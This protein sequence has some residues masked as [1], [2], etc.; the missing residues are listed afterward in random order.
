ME[1]HKAE[2]QNMVVHWPLYRDLPKSFVM[3]VY[4]CAGVK[5]VWKCLKLQLFKD[6]TFAIV[7]M[8]SCLVTS[9]DWAENRDGLYQKDNIVLRRGS[10]SALI[11]RHENFQKGALKMLLTLSPP[12]IFLEQSAILQ[13][14]TIL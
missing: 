11:G 3:H 12:N 6:H 7:T 14:F 5:A 13:G 4:L 2:L 9:Q 1:I 8:T 10:F